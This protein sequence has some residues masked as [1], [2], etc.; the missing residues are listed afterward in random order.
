MECSICMS[1]KVSSPVVTRCGHLFCWPC[2]Y[3]WLDAQLR[4]PEN[5]GQEAG[6][7]PIC[8]GALSLHRAEPGDFTPIYTGGS[9]V[10]EE[11]AETMSAIPPRPQA[12]RLAEPT[13]HPAQGAGLL[14]E[15]LYI[16]MDDLFQEAASDYNSYPI[17]TPVEVADSLPEVNDGLYNMESI[18]RA[19]S[20]PFPHPSIM[21]GAH[22]DAVQGSGALGMPAIQGM[23]SPSEY[24]YSPPWNIMQHH[25]VEDT[26]SP[27]YI[28]APNPYSQR[29]PFTAG[30]SYPHLQCH[31]LLLQQHPQDDLHD[32]Y[33][34]FHIDFDAQDSF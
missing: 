14:T 30:A 27:L 3:T 33:T 31:P 12:A 4:K 34:S 22:V 11:E 2:I 29:T 1:D 8:K 6:T 5:I 20:Y 23:T 28:V 21:D 32:V 15:D 25:I 13:R 26:S 17:L 24:Y 16:Y 10:K 9:H 7:C 18:G 19:Y